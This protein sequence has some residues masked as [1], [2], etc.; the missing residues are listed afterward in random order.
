M[1]EAAG[2]LEPGLRKRKLRPFGGHPRDTTP[3]HPPLFTLTQPQFPGIPKFPF[4]TKNPK[5]TT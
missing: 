3:D 4:I 1:R 5:H 2:G